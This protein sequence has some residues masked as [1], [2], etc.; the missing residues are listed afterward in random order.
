MKEKIWKNKVAAVKVL[1]GRYLSSIENNNISVITFTE[2]VN[3]GT[4]ISM[5]IQ[6]DAIYLLSPVRFFN[7][8]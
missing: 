4:I 3:I 6:A 1:S 2:A 7:W 8:L 5:K